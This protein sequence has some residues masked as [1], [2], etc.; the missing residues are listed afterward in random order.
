MSFEGPVC[1]GFFTVKWHDV[2]ITVVSFS[3]LLS[4]TLVKL[5]SVD[6]VNIDSVILLKAWEVSLVCCLYMTLIQFCFQIYKRNE[7]KSF[8][9]LLNYF[10][11][12]V[13]IETNQSY[14]SLSS[15]CHQFTIFY[16]SSRM[17]NS[18]FKI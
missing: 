8:L 7:T 4:L 13:S 17:Q 15:H 5:G 16:E 3:I 2:V 1:K 9:Q 10:D 11:Q 14:A 12:D 6:A 18:T